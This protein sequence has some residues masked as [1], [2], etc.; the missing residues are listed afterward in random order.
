MQKGDIAYKVI[1]K[2]TRLGTNLV[3]HR[4]YTTDDKIWEFNKYHP[5]LFP[6]YL[7]GKKLEAEEWTEGYL[8]FK[9]KERAKDFIRRETLPEDNVELIRIRL[10]DE[11][12]RLEEVLPCCGEHPLDICKM[13]HSPDV[14]LTISAPM[15]TWACHKI[16]VLD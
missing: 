2:D 16:E 11:P 13:R 15:G 9:H 4:K 7:K 3:L 10:L 5:K 1:E 8:V 6:R 12:K 14:W